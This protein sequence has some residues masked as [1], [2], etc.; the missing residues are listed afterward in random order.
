M[1]P[2]VRRSELVAFMVSGPLDG[3]QSL[4]AAGIL[5]D[6][7]LDGPIAEGLVQANHL[8]SAKRPFVHPVAS[9]TEERPLV[10]LQVNHLRARQAVRASLVGLVPAVHVWLAQSHCTKHGKLPDV[11]VLQGCL[12]RLHGEVPGVGQ[13][14]VVVERHLRP[15]F[16][17]ETTDA[18]EPAPL[19]AIL[20][21]QQV[22]GTL[23]CASADAPD[24]PELVDMVLLAKVDNDYLRTTMRFHVVV[25]HVLHVLPCDAAPRVAGVHLEPPPS[26]PGQIR[27]VHVAVGIVLGLQVDERLLD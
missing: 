25:K 15:A 4:G 18:F 26:G 21:V 13:I 10:G 1:E 23:S 5:I 3:L 20:G 17:I 8:S 27:V 7:C 11:S 2:V 19:L 22:H 14:Q 16:H 24:N 6:L 9:A 12:L